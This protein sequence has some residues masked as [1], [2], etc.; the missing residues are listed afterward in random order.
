[1]TVDVVQFEFANLENIKKALS[2]EWNWTDVWFNENRDEP[3]L[4]CQGYG[5]LADGEMEG[6]FA[7]RIARAVWGA[8]A[9]FCYV[10]V[11]VTCLEG[12]PYESYSFDELAYE[13]MQ[14]P[15][16]INKEDTSWPGDLENQ[17]PSD[18]MER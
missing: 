5:S 10:E 2:H 4:F 8:N 14:T 16:G 18:S 12:L 7:D 9:G 1:M 3:V 11:S 6:A 13:D 17:D 15:A